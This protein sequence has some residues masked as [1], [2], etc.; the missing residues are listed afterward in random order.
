MS[1]RLAINWRRCL[2]SHLKATR[3]DVLR[4]T[5]KLD[6][7]PHGRDAR[8][9]EPN[10]ESGRQHLP[11]HR[12]ALWRYP[13]ASRIDCPSSEFLSFSQGHCGSPLCVQSPRNCCPSLPSA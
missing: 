7:S 10:S 6:A 1:R 2:H 11:S 5:H 9:L 13:T 4:L 8:I 12:H 3:L